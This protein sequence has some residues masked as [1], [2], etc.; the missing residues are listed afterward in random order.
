M[1]R[2]FA[3]LDGAERP[4]ALEIAVITL[5]VTAAL[6]ILPFSVFVRAVSTRPRRTRQPAV[7]PR[8]TAQLVEGVARRIP[9]AT[10]LVQAV[11]LF[12][13]LLRRGIATEVVVA[14]A[15]ASGRLDA[16]A[17]VRFEDSAILGGPEREGYAPLLILRADTAS[18]AVAA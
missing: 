16:H 6:R 2:R 12:H 9:A 4:L 5:A 15:R 8:R 18:S 3:S 17:W 11:V 14:A 10:C 13:V 7:S 1:V